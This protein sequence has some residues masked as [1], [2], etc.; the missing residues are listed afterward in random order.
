MHP[1]LFANR[2]N[3]GYV[4]DLQMSLERAETATVLIQRTAISIKKVVQLCLK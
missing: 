4:F 3:L 1:S 2:K